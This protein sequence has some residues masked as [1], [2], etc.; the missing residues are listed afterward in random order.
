M[1]ELGGAIVLAGGQSERMGQ[2]KALITVHGMTLLEHVIVA[3]MP[4][5]N[6][7]LV[8]ADIPDKYPLSCGRVVADTFP[9]C[10]P[11]GG[12]LTGLTALGA[13]Y[14][15]VVGCDMPA[16]QLGVLQLLAKAVMPGWDAFVPM[17]GGQAEPL[18]AIYSHTAG[19]KLLRFLESDRRS[20]REAL[21]MLQV[22]WLGEGVLRRVDPQLISFTNVN[23]PEDLKALERILV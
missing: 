7:I 11:V 6:K 4:V 13:G 21:D 18:C 19:P 1:E 16:L 17:I 9:G 12:I 3:L 5:V 23:A 22:K 2:D 10:G 8:V 20:A 14:H 15:L